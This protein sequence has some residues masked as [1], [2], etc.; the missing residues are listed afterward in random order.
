MLL[1]AP[2]SLSGLAAVPAAAETP[3]A[4]FLPI[5]AILDDPRPEQRVR[6]S[7]SLVQDLGDNEFLVEDATGRI[8]VEGG[9]AWYHR[10]GLPADELLIIDGEVEVEDGDPPEIDI[11]Q[12]TREDGAVLRIRPATGPSPW[13]GRP[14][15][16]GTPLSEPP[17]WE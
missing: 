14:A 6:I 13:S 1:S 11:H 15:A 4:H 12:V 10:F 17:V 8:I 16:A 3:A 5:A 9:P 2:A 7:A